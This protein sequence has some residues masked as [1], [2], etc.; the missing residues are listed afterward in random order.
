MSPNKVS[1]SGKELSIGEIETFFDITERSL[2]S[3]YDQ[4]N[5]I[6]TGYTPD[7]LINELDSRIEELDRCTTLTAIAAIEAHVRVDF[8]Q[9]C[10][11]KNKDDLSRKFRALHQTKGP[12]VSLPDD[13]L[14]LWKDYICSK[15]LI[16]DLRSV[17]NYR[18]WLAHGRYWVA[19]LGR[20]KYDL[21]QVVTLAFLLQSAMG[22]DMGA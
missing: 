17:L 12:N 3:Y 2:R 1:L 16:S 4:G 18:H 15:S 6:F 9:R 8:L 22:I 14:T 10:Y 11:F 7:E 20:D 21:R 5:P 13:I 19:K